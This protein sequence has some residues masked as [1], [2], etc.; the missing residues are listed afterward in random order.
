MLLKKTGMLDYLKDWECYGNNGNN[1]DDNIKIICRRNN[2]NN[3]IYVGDT[4]TD[5]EAC[6]ASGVKFIWASYGFGNPQEYFK[7]IDKFSDL[8]KLLGKN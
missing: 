2:L 5:C 3:A 6:K 8:F 4:Q 1:K 7:K